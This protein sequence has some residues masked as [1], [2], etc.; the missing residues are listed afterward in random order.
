[1]HEAGASM[2]DHAMREERSGWW[3]SAPTVVL[4]VALLIVPTLA[5]AALSLTD[6]DL[7]EN[8]WHFVGLQNYIDL[9][10]DRTFRISIWNTA[11]Y[12]VVVTPVSVVLGLGCAM[13]I[14][15][16]DDLKGLFRSAY[17][18]P[19]VSLIVAMA[20]VWQYLMHPTIGPINL[21]LNLVG[22]PSVNFLGSSDVVIYG[23]AII[24]IWQATGFAMVLFLAGLTAIDP[25]LY[26]AAEI[27]GAKS[28]F[29]RFR[30]VT[31]PMLAPTTL[32]V[33]TIT[34]INAVKV[35]ET[36]TTLTQGGPSKASE[37]L[38]W[39]I[40]EEGFIYLHLGNASAMAVIFVL[41]LL[42][43]IVIQTRVLDKRVHY[44]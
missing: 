15:A 11:V 17:F 31:W 10:S 38:L 7:G 6:V 29:D 40:Y 4:V 32:F 13:L 16:A 33:T 1:M 34:M 26:H 20:T 18:L 21:L 44:G 27:D 39:T 22:L 37:V 8:E 35:F 9:A 3:L 2:S 24:G 5:M 25:Q 14:E 28:G 42:V 43:L 30:L 36:V 12:V 19:V 41:V 23:L